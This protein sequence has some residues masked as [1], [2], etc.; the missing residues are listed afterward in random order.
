VIDRLYLQTSV[1][2]PFLAIEQKLT[3]PIFEVKDSIGCWEK[4][5]FF[6]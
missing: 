6:V 3:K 1:S 4:Q 2:L 5:Q